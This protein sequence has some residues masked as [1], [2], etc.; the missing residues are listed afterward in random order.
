MVDTNL[1]DHSDVIGGR[2][3][4]N[5]DDTCDESTTQRISV[6]PEKTEEEIESSQS[7]QLGGGGGGGGEWIPN[8]LTYQ[9]IRPGEKFQSFITKWRKQ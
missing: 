7:E 2:N 6:E 4:V 8:G 5:D 3:D 1:D 9:T